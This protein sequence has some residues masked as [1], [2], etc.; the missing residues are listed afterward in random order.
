MKTRLL[1]ITFLSLLIASFASCNDAKQKE[2]TEAKTVQPTVAAIEGK[3]LMEQKCNLCHSPS[4]QET[5]RIAPPMVAVKSHYLD[6]NTSKEEFANAIWNFV[7]KPSKAKS[8][9]KGAVFNFGLMPYQPF[10]EGDI[11]K[12]ADY[13]YDYKIEEPSLNASETLT[14]SEIGMEYALS[15]KKEL[16]KNLMGT[17]QSKG[18]LEAVTFCNKQAYPITD[19]MA[20]A[21]NAKIKR[22]SDQPRNPENQASVKEI[23]YI[24]DFKRAIA[25]GNEV[26]PIVEHTNGM[27]NFYYPITTNTMCL[28][29][30]GNSKTQIEPLVLNTIKNLYPEDKA[31]EYDVNQVRGIWAI[32]FDD[33]S[34]NK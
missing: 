1:E 27:T 19:S 20:T 14:P 28:Q 31:L 10:N 4:S 24:K 26:T 30:H 5:G 16:G 33:N 21:Q 25:A 22:V 9:M 12:I 7:E 6:D 15:T 29:C 18:T 13:I 32:T 11:R 34:I 2:Y 17:I 23:K 3:K 8:K